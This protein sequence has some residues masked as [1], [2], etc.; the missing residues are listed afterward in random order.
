MYNTL[1]ESGINIA[2]FVYNMEWDDYLQ[3]I[4]PR[5][6]GYHTCLMAIAN[7]SNITVIDICTINKTNK[8]DNINTSIVWYIYTAAI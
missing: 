2:D 6:Q 3:G 8:F 4:K 7:T 1:P 5:D